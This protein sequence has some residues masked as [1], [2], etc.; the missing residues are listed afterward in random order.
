LCGAPPGARA[1]E[2]Q[3]LHFEGFDLNGL[4]AALTD[5][6]ISLQVT[7]SNPNAT[8]RQA[9]VVLRYA[10]D[11]DVQYARDIWVPAR[12]SIATWM[13]AGPAPDVDAA[14]DGV[15]KSHP[16][17]GV[18]KSHP[19][20][21]RDLQ[22]LLF[23]ITGGVERFVPPAQGDRPRS[24]YMTYRKREPITCIMIDPA[25]A[26][27]DLNGGFEAETDN[28]DVVPLV[29]AFRAAAAL[30]GNV[31]SYEGTFLPPTA[32]GFDGVEHFVLA[33]R[34][35]A[36]DPAGLQALRRWVLE[37][38]KLWVM[39]D[40]VE[41]ETVAQL[42]ND[43]T[44]FQVVDRTTLTTVRIEDRHPLRGE[45]EP[46]VQA[47]EQ[48]VD[49]VRVALTPEYKVL[50]T[51]NGWPAAFARDLGRGKVIVTTLAARAW[52]RPRVINDASLFVPRVPNPRM[53][54]TTGD[55]QS[56]FRDYPDLPVP[57]PAFDT[58]TRE[59]QS[60]PPP[61]PFQG[62]EAEKLVNSDIG[63]SVIGVGTAALVFGA[64]LTFLL[65]VGLALRHWGRGE[66]VGWLGPVGAVAATVV[67]V[68][69]A[70]AS[71]RAVPPSVAV[72]QMVNVTPGAE[73]QP[74]VG[75]LAFYRPEGGPVP[76]ST[77]EGGMP[78]LNMEGM[79]GQVRRLVVTDIDTW[80]WDNL[81]LPGGVRIGKFHYVAHT[82][83]P[84]A[85]VARFGPEGLEGT[86]TAGAFQGLSDAVVRGPTGRAVALRLGADDHFTAGP[87]DVLAPDQ[88]VRGAVLTDR[89]QQHQGVYRE[90]AKTLDK[91]PPDRGVLFAWAEPLKVPFT[92]DPN[93]RTTGTAL[94]T[95]PLEFQPPPPGTHVTV[96]RP[97]VA[98]TRVLPDRI[99]VVPTLEGEAAIKMELRFRVPASVL[100][101]KLEGARLFLKATAPDRRFTVRGTGANG[102]V[103][104]VDVEGSTDP[105]QRD[106]PE[107]LL[108]LDEDGGLHLEVE[109]GQAPEEREPPRAGR[110]GPK[111]RRPPPKWRIDT[112]GLQITG[113]TL[114][115]R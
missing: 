38:G 70:N 114:P 51:V 28:G 44:G 69:L 23:D 16:Q 88:Y 31:R 98:Y 84:A 111:E 107:A 67:F 1:Q 99:E 61:N 50:H 45:H 76:F 60:P 79:E 65:A 73:E 64:F 63:Y 59:L 21:A 5:H 57:L 85:A 68:V 92:L 110:G 62:Q 71:R 9:R 2:D 17:D 105:L 109:V 6:W 102:R 104:V 101:L 3:P 54:P 47:L 75:T 26:P 19:Q 14:Q 91:N 15:D 87:D 35:L 74:A 96:P 56:P 12:S 112:L 113:Q 66:L 27:A 86:L 10:T 49:F 78:E 43:S 83:K 41:P 18:D 72:A 37:G 115:E 4:H 8:A 24:R 81:G 52:F 32:E 89:Q 77:T 100:P 108:R 29:R 80:H 97:F 30:S 20:N 42:L 40:L 94:L 103:E 95:V 106:L 93:A 25:A 55:P 22:F 36:D 33:T 58:L 39:L 13:L 34:R 7:V 82:G 11:P 90:L 48:P 46:S 53:Q